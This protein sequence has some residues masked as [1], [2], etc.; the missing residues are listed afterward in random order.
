MYVKQLKDGDVLT[1]SEDA[2]I[3]LVPREEV[4]EAL[5]AANKSSSSDEAVPPAPPATPAPPPPPPPPP[6]PPCWLEH[7]N[8]GSRKRV[9]Q[10]K[11]SKV[12]CEEV[13]S[14][15]HHWCSDQQVRQAVRD[16]RRPRRPAQVPRRRPGTS[17]EGLRPRPVLRPG[18]DGEGGGGGHAQE[19]CE[20][21][22]DV[23][24]AEGR[25]SR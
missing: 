9:F 23:L 7:P 25:E 4:V 17:G 24:K 3:Q 16:R 1:Y 22:W 8:K 14:F 2:G 12:R 21:R 18:G 10:V 20:K 13:F 19:G 15:N 5:V 11:K 6:A